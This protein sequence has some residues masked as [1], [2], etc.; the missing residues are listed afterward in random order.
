MEGGDALRRPGAGGAGGYLGVG[1]SEG[2]DRRSSL[3]LADWN[4]NLMMSD[5]RSHPQKPV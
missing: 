1:G 5:D 4:S 2:T 3:F